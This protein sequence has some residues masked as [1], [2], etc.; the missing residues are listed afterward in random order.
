LEIWLT[1]KNKNSSNRNKNK[2]SN[3]SILQGILMEEMQK[4]ILATIAYYDELGYPLTAFEV[5][6]YLTRINRQETVSDEK[7]SLINIINELKNENLNKYI[8]EY[9]GFYFLQGRRKLVGM[10]LNRT[11][12][13]VSKIKRLRKVAWLMRLMPFVKMIGMTGRLAMKNTQKKSDWDVL[14]VLKHGHIWTGRTLLTIFLQ[15]IGKRRHG[16]KMMDRVCLN[17]FITDC[18]LEIKNQDIF[19]ASEYFF[20]VPLFGKKTY[21]KF[22]KANEWIREFKPNFSEPEKISDFRLVEDSQVAKF[23]R[24][25]GEFIFG[26]KFIEDFLRSIEKKKIENNP[27]THLEG[28]QVEAT[29]ETLIFLPKPQAPRVIARFEEKI[30][31][32]KF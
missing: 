22:L 20:L 13:A 18:S 29:D 24:K 15:L 7:Y 32:L 17:Y 8:E 30:A 23:I 3:E 1:T 25:S 28:S 6:K 10:R 5:W 31:H 2:S 19:S 27:L 21:H 16:E 14:V 11:K 26:W 4:E 12:I 9:R